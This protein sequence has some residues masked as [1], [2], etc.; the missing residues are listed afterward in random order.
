LPSQPNVLKARIQGIV[1]RVN[2][3]FVLPLLIKHRE[4]AF[5]FTRA[6]G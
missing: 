1:R 2:A 3:L 4:D 5:D 6:G